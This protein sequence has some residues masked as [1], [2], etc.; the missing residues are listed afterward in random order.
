MERKNSSADC[1]FE[2]RSMGDL[3]IFRGYLR[4]LPYD[5][6]ESVTGDYVWLAALKFSEARRADFRKRRECCREECVR[7]GVPHLYRLAEQVVSPWA[8]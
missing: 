3:A 7:R 2:Y 5:L 6:L 8:A 4:S 1:V